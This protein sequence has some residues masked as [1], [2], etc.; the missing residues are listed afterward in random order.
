MTKEMTKGQ[1]IFSRILTI[2][3]ILVVAGTVAVVIITL[4]HKETEVDNYSDNIIEFDN[5]LSQKEF[6]YYVY[7]YR[8]EC[9]ACQ[10]IS[11]NI[12]EYI[13]GYKDGNSAYK[14]YLLSTDTC[15]DKIVEFDDDGMAKSNLYVSDVS[16]LRI[17]STPCLLLVQNGSV[18]SG[19]YGAK[20]VASQLT[21]R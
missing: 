1:K 15:Y 20:S 16:E 18:L 5:A 21:A 13:D 2:L 3:S 19:I 17:S 11:K 12:T 10:S 7:I 9:T 4:C 8:E 14:L 6:T